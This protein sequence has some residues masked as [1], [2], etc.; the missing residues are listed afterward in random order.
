M[1]VTITRCNVTIK[2]ARNIIFA[3]ITSWQR[4]KRA[5]LERPAQHFSN[6]LDEGLFKA[7]ILSA[8]LINGDQYIH[9]FL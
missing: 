2:A 5:S 9:T 3:G 7:F 4:Q 1:L 6:L 8:I